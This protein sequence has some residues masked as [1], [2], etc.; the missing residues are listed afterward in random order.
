MRKI[1]QVACLWAAVVGMAA[2]TVS[3]QSDGATVYKAKCAS[4]HGINGT[5]PA[6][7]AKSMGVKAASDPAV[8]SKSLAQMVELTRKGIGKMPGYA[9]KLTDAQIKDSVE[10]FRSLGK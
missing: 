9:G 3:A 2:V 8:K 4:C 10:Y 7:M 6:A 1:V 5:A